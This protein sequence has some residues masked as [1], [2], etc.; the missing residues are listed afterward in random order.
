[1]TCVCVTVVPKIPASDGDAKNGAETKL[2]TPRKNPISSIAAL[3][4]AARLGRG[5]GEQR[6]EKGEHGWAAGA[7]ARAEAKRLA[8]QGRAAPVGHGRW[9]AIG[10]KSNALKKQIAESKP[11]GKSKPPLVN[12]TSDLPSTS[13]NA[14]RTPSIPAAPGSTTQPLGALPPCMSCLLVCSNERCSEMVE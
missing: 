3:T 5:W 8:K 11:A 12:N 4:V 6:L 10:K 7:R 13:V 2:L 14:G 1:M 9:Q